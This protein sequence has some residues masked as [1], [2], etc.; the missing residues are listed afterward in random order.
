MERWININKQKPDYGEVVEVLHAI[1]GAGAPERP[2]FA[3][4]GKARY[5][6][7]SATRSLKITPMSCWVF[8]MIKHEPGYN[9]LDN[10]GLA[11]THWRRIDGI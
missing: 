4:K 1:T 6:E 10:G 8:E 3:Y 11:P 9:I 5:R 2:A 7:P